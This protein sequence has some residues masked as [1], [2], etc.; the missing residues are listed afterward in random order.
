MDFI[1]SLSAVIALITGLAG[2]ISAAITAYI[3]VK[4]VIKANEG[5][6]FLEI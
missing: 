3:S 5:K 1:N 6:S 4:K 2:L